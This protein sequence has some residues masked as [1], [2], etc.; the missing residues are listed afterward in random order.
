MRVLLVNLKKKH[1][2]QYN[3][4]YNNKKESEL[5]RTQ[6]DTSE[7]NFSSNINTPFSIKKMAKITD[8][9]FTIEEA[10]ETKNA[11][12]VVKNFTLL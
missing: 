9:H 2:I 5:P 3:E 6:S 10:F 7:E 4:L 8:G 12:S 11:E 1:P